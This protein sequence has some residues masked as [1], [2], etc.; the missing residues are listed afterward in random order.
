MENWKEI[1][2]RINEMSETPLIKYTNT[3]VKTSEIMSP[4][5]MKK[6]WDLLH[7]D[8]Y[9][10]FDVLAL[11]VGI[12]NIRQSGNA[13]KKWYG[14]RGWGEIPDRRPLIEKYSEEIFNHY[15][16]GMKGNQIA[17]LYPLS[18]I[19]IMEMLKSKYG[20]DFKT[21]FEVTD[22]M[23]KE[24]EKMLSE[25]LSSRKIGKLFGCHGTTVLKYTKEYRKSLS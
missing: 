7:E 18:A 13:A 8:L 6:L 2:N 3:F 12:T 23:V 16:N 14:N 24:W 4:E 20:V 19:T 1:Q 11:S 15:N 21:P 5:R 9:T 22:N 10:S 25:G 17:K